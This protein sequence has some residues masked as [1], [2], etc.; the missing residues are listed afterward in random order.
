M[1]GAALEGEGFTL[2]AFREEESLYGARGEG[3]F[4]RI[5]GS[6][7]ATGSARRWTRGA[8]TFELTGEA[9]V[10]DPKWRSILV[11]DAD[12]VW[13]SAFTAEVRR[14]LGKHSQ[15][16]LSLSQPLRVERASVD[17]NLPVAR[18]PGTGRIV[19]AK[20]RVDL[21]P[22]GRQLDVEA[23]FARRIGSEGLLRL[24]LVRSHEPGHVRNAKP[25]WE[26]AAGLRLR[27]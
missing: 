16:G 24:E 19:R 10:A 3:A 1:S 27:W 5:S 14:W 6:S 23:S 26:A 4:G 9:G 20:R 22:S 18:E 12:T 8:W 21:E 11:E 7:L 15:A 17:L 2:T 13:T 25:A